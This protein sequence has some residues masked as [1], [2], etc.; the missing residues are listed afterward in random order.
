MGK[1]PETTREGSFTSGGLQK[2]SVALRPELVSAIDRLAEERDT[3]RSKAIA[4]LAKLGME[5]LERV[6]RVSSIAA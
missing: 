2:F 6:R 1:L 5:E 4:L 3:S